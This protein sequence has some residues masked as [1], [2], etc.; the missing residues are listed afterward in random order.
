MCRYLPLRDN[1]RRFLYRLALIQIYLRMWYL[2]PFGYVAY[3]QSVLILALM[4]KF[5]GQLVNSL[6]Y[7]VYLSY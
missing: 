2:Q 4:A 3:I 5:V 6:R 7:S 1:Y